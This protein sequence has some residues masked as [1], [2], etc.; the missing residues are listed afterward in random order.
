[1]SSSVTLGHTADRCNS[2]CWYREIALPWQPGGVGSRKGGGGGGGDTYCTGSE[3]AP[4]GRLSNTLPSIP[5]STS[6]RQHRNQCH[7]LEVSQA[8]STNTGVTRE[9]GS[10]GQQTHRVP[11]PTVPQATRLGSSVSRCKSTWLQSELLPSLAGDTAA[12]HHGNRLSILQYITVY[13]SIPQYTVYH[14]IS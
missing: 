11:Y 12:E 14:S 3:I 8:C 7:K 13:H 10:T 9:L 1:M 5:I 2:L 6:P 4:T